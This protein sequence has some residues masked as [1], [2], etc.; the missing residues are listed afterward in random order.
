MLGAKQETETQ[1]GVE[2]SALPCR[3]DCPSFWQLVRIPAGCATTIL[4]HGGNFE[5]GFSDHSHGFRPN[6]SAHTALKQVQAHVKEGY[7]WAVDMDLDKFF[8]TV[9]HDVLIHRVAR[10]VHDKRILKLIGKYLRAGVI[11]N[12]QVVPT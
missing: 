11:V 2:P 4:A 6:R 7:R 1:E 3:P 8:D 5:P 9:D 10:K 12:G